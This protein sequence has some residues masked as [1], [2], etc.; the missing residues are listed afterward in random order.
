M[1]HQRPIATRAKRR[2]NT[3]APPTPFAVAIACGII[4]IMW[5]TVAAAP[6][7][8]AAELRMAEFPDVPIRGKIL[9][10]DPA[11]A[12]VD[13]EAFSAKLSVP[14]TWIASVTPAAPAPAVAVPSDPT[15]DPEEWVR[16][17]EVHLAQENFRAAEA[18]FRAA[19]AAAPEHRGARD[20]VLR[21]EIDT[22]TRRAF[23]DTQT[24]VATDFSPY[25]GAGATVAEYTAFVAVMMAVEL[26]SES[27][28]LARVQTR[29]L[30]REREKYLA[31]VARSNRGTSYDDRTAAQLAEMLGKI[32]QLVER[33]HEAAMTDAPRFRNDP[34]KRVAVMR[35]VAAVFG[36]AEAIEAVLANADALWAKAHPPTA[37]ARVPDD[38]AT[39][40][41]AIIR[42]ENARL[43]PEVFSER[44]F[45]LVVAT[46][47]YREL[48]GL[49]RLRVS[50]ELTQAAK[51]HSQS[52]D[53]GNYFA[54]RGSDGSSP[55]ERALR[56]GFPRRSMVGENI[57]R[58][59]EA[60]D[61]AD[62]V[63][64]NW[65]K[66]PGH[67][68]AICRAEFRFLGVGQS[69]RLWTQVFG[70]PAD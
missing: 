43:G 19:L 59:A 30:A 49:D 57:Q 34:E 67:H 18:A 39:V 6:A 17:G 24:R 51:A 68:A 48:L 36:H 60:T 62:V 26:Q 27:A 37:V 55:T 61:P 3:N 20:G 7:A 53:S 16:R 70:T 56:A 21:F 45:A 50:R 65:Q 8:Q 23:R 2:A 10:N 5:A 32:T 54:H 63:L 4:I 40:R 12:T 1:E 13:F 9:A 22:L 44:E 64:R 38:A 33:P 47:D 52:M 14:R 66:S 69:N 42:A 15:N 31:Q 41:N 46:N 35:V 29:T 28:R 11:S 25:H 58:A